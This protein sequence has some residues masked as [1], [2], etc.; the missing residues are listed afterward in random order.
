MEKIVEQL[1]VILM[2]SY[3]LYYFKMYIKDL[4]ST[5]DSTTNT[6]TDSITNTTTDPTKSDIQDEKYSNIIIILLFECCPN[7]K[8]IQ[9]L[10]LLLSN[11][12]P[13]S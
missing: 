13:E 1:H 2:L 9:S 7:Q 6:T 12:Y 8:R 5:T 11:W 4:D 3:D 10:Q